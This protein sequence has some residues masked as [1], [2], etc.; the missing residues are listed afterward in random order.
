MTDEERQ[1][2]LTV[3]WMFIRH[4]RRDRAR[5][6]CE[7]LIEADSRDGVAALALAEILVSEGDAKAALG[8]LDSADVPTRL[9]HAEA[10]IETRALRLAGRGAEAQSR[11]RRYLEAQKGADRQWTA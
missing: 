4:G 1:F 6:L 11:W 5:S 7:A 9:A 3:A 10:V 2:L 8:V